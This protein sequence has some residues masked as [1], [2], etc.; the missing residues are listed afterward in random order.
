VVECYTVSLMLEFYTQ[1]V[2]VYLQRSRRSSL[3]KCVAAQTREKF[4]KVLYFGGS[5]SF[6]I[7][8]LIVDELIAVK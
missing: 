5:R 1:V 2:L 7:I 6:E 3:L 4:T 8:V